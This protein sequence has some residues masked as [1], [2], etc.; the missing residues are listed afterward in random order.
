MA[1]QS[2]AGGSRATLN[3]Q[4]TIYWLTAPV[5]L[6]SASLYFPSNLGKE[7]TSTAVCI[8]KQIVFSIFFILCHFFCLSFPSKLLKKDYLENKRDLGIF[9]E[10]ALYISFCA[11]VAFLILFFFK[12]YFKF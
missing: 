2:L 10:V 11:L 1:T 7:I 4:G 8:W 9:R 5:S 12:L 3:I 6:A